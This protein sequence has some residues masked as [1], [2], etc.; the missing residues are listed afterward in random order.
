MYIQ[1]KKI[2][3]RSKVA[4]KKQTCKKNNTMWT[5]RT[6]NQTSPSNNSYIGKND[7]VQF[8]RDAL[9]KGVYFGKRRIY[10]ADGRQAGTLAKG[11]SLQ[12]ANTPINKELFPLSGKSKIRNCYTITNNVKL[13]EPVEGADTSVLYITENGV[14]EMT[15]IALDPLDSQKGNQRVNLN[16]NDEAMACWN[17][18]L[19]GLDE[20]MT[21]YELNK[22]FSLVDRQVHSTKGGSEDLP[23]LKEEEAVKSVIDEYTYMCQN[24]IKKNE[25]TQDEANTSIN[26]F[27]SRM[28]EVKGEV[29]LILGQI[30]SEN[31]TLSN[32]KSDITKKYNY[33]LTE[34]ML[35]NAGFRV[36]PHGT[37]GTWKVG[38]HV[39]KGTYGWEHWWLKTPDGNYIDHWP[40]TGTGIRKW[41]VMPFEV[42]DDDIIEVPI[43]DIKQ[44]HKNKAGI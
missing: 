21:V 11:T 10:G 32:T 19:Y 3:N 22:V 28:D 14:K 33:K 15:D 1:K 30:N 44:E 31:V 36:L 13:L 20:N 7:I 29:A 2:D 18:A 26:N 35:S 37:E 27:Q 9:V 39:K 38:Q 43:A 16:H 40:A 25:M 23:Q 6:L 41:K 8:Y 34:L 5:L 24:R 17:W 4:I 12:V 42:G